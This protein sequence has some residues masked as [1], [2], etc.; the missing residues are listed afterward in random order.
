MKRVK[1]LLVATLFAWTIAHCSAINAQ[2]FEGKIVYKVSY[3]SKIKDV[4]NDQMTAFM[5]EDHV[6]Y[7]KGGD[8]KLLSNGEF[9]ESQL[10]IH[11]E[12]RLYNKTAQSD[13]LYWI[14]GAFEDT[15]V[16]SFRFLDET[17]EVLGYKCKMF[18]VVESTG[19]TTYFVNEQF[20]MDPSL[21]TNHNFGNWG[22]VIEKT[23]A[24][25]MKYIS[26]REEYNVVTIAVLVEPMTLPQSLFRLEGNPPV[27]AMPGF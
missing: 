8:Y 11:S 10:Y 21:F 9:F 27:M 12:N 26:E 22:F 2:S 3:E 14:D 19:K 7:L 1:L 24:L 5:G 23:R 25:S 13:T 4:S 18:E 15:E 20:E 16:M 17:A 6:Y